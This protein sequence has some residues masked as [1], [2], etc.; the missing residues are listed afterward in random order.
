MGKDV[1]SSHRIE[2]WIAVE[3]R[4]IALVSIF[5]HCYSLGVTVVLIF[6]VE[7]V[8]DCHACSDFLNM[9]QLERVVEAQIADEIWIQRIFFTLKIVEILAAN[10]L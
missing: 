8:V 2:A 4:L 10:I 3:R 1:G 5:I 6:I 7:Q 9:W